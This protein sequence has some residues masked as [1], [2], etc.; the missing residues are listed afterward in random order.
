MDIS[1]ARPRRTAASRGRRPIWSSPSTTPSPEAKAASGNAP[2]SP[3]RVFG[4]RKGPGLRQRQAALLDRFLP[5][6]AIGTEADLSRPGALFDPPRERVWLEIGFGGGE[7]LAFEA[8]RHPEVGFIG[9]EPFLNGVVKLL[10]AVEAEGLLNVRIHVGDGRRIVDA[11]GASSIERVFLLFPDPWPK[12][13]HRKRRFVSADTLAG[14]H[15]VL[16][17]G[18]RFRFASDSADYVEHTLREVER[19]GG[20]QRVAGEFGE[21]PVTRYEAKAIAAGR[22][23]AV[24]DFARLTAGNCEA[25]STSL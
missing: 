7:H 20:F 24:F 14:L 23:C 15:R 6:L 9:C 17:P 22:A 16:K 5:Q 21:R 4:R 18:G 3:Y 1:A 11:L 10:G 13:R 12:R 2:A 25:F 8:K 19:H